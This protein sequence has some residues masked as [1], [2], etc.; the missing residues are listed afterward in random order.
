MTIVTQQKD[1]S[2]YLLL[3]MVQSLVWFFLLPDLCRYVWPVVFDRIPSQTMKEVVLNQT[4]TIVFIIYG[5]CI[6]PIY[7]IQH[8]FFEQFKILKG[9]PWP[10]LDENEKTKKEF[11][12]MTRKSFRLCAFN[13]LFLV[14]LA[15]IMKSYV[16]QNFLLSDEGSSSPILS[17]DLK[18][19][20]TK[21]DLLRDNILLT[22]LHE[23][24]FH[25]AHRIMHI[26]P[27][28]YKFHKVHHEYKSNTFIAAQH[29]HPVDYLMSIATPVLTAI[30]IVQPHSCTQFVW[31]IWVL[32]ANLDDHVGYSFPF[33]PVRWFPFAAKTQEHEFHHSVN[34]GCFSSKLDV[35]ER[36]FQTNRKY[37]TWEK[38]RID[39][40]NHDAGM[41][42]AL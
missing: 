15:T 42:K 34:I 8:P 6:L 5:L 39:S 12:T 10:W 31:V 4:A 32:Y 20:P 35:F 17:F 25:S 26:Y 9:R 38:R 13:L 28:L 1:P 33:S 11:W 21:G 2:I 40:H 27:K 30:M 37:L 18:D 14:P 22:L 41:K 7:Y 24:F 36:L 3:A 29:N 16:Q 23:F 19:W